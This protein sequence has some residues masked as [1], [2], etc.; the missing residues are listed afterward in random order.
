MTIT[1]KDN[2]I[3]KHIRKLRDKKF[4][5]E[6]NEFVIE[7]LKMLEEAINEKIKI[8]MIIVCD[9]YLISPK[10]KK[11]LLY[12]LAKEKVIYVNEKVFKYISEV[13]TPQGIL[14]VVEKNKSDEI[15]YSK[16]LFLIL[17]NIQ[18]PGNMGTILRTAD[19]IGL[20]QI[21]VS[22]GTADSYNSK[23]VRSTM[24]AIF[25]INIIEVI[26][27]VDI[28]KEFKKHKIQIFATD[29]ATTDSI[30]DVNYKKSAIIIGNEGNGVS[31]EILE[32]SDK[33]IKI[34]MP[35]KTESLNASVA[36]GIIL[37][38]AIRSMMN[39]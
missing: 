22:K 21:I 9:E 12:K 6:N 28:I 23:V 2:E 32:K 35:G 10:I 13:T 17:D 20:N 4:R 14:A 3:I 29:L 36:T 30:Y 26:D 16:D 39:S 24:G 19:S 1:S 15:D 8:K 33:K 5:D 34:P 37:Y 38:N 18:D 25:R 7:G 27:L 31:K 11:E